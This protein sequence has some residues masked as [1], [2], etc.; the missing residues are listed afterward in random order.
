MACAALTRQEIE[1]RGLNPC[2]Y[3]ALYC[4]KHG[5]LRLTLEEPPASFQPCPACERLSLCVLLGEGGTR[6]PLPFW[7]YRTHKP[8]VASELLRMLKIQE[9]RRNS[10]APS[11]GLPNT[12]ANRIAPPGGATWLL[13]TVTIPL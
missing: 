10:S 3:A 6:L 7:G 12:G 4:K 1:P 13:H 5:E 2:F 9:K 8:A 11:Q